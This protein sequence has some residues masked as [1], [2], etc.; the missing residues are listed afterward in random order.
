VASVYLYSLEK[1][2]TLN[3]IDDIIILSPALYWFQICEIPTKS[4][5]KAKK[6]ATHMISNKPENFKDIEL[7]YKENGYYAYA[8]D[9]NSIQTLLKKLDLQNPKVYFANQLQI[10]QLTAIDNETNLYTFHKRVIESPATTK[11]PSKSLSIHYKELLLKEKPIRSLE[12]DDRSLKS[13]LSIATGFFLLY[14]ILFAF[15]KISTL[16]TLNHTMENLNT[17][18][19]SFYQIKSLIRKYTKLD[20]NSKNFKEKLTQA[21]QETN[22]QSL[23]YSDGTLKITKEK[24]KK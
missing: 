1:K 7:F 5:T 15:D 22:L 6:I 17:H 12:S 4:I 13:L 21:L 11:N 16:N 3:T 14:I 19:R 10:T 20:K 24:V 18:N 2:T 23:I 8:Y 9:K